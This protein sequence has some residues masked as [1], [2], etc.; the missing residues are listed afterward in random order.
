MAR[1]RHF[2]L[3]YRGSHSNSWALGDNA[4]FETRRRPIEMDGVGSNAIF[5]SFKK[6]PA[7]AAKGRRMQKTSQTT[8]KHPHAFV[9][10]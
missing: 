7:K 1:L 3:P 9:F 6:R 2:R 8:V 5:A 10:V 4:F